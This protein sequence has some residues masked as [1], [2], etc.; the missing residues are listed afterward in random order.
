M[1][2]YNKFWVAI[3]GA[4]TTA[5]AAGLLPDPVAEWVPV[6][7]AFATALGVVAVPNTPPPGE[8]ADPNVSEMGPNY[9]P[10]VAP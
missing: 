2:R 4:L 5:A 10:E 3:L 8:P 1:S 6:V 7:I 9:D